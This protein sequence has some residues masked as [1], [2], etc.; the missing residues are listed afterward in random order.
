M[1][2]SRPESVSLS[3]AR[4]VPSPQGVSAGEGQA[5]MKPFGRNVN[6]GLRL[7]IGFLISNAMTVLAWAGEHSS[8]TGDTVAPPV[9]LQDFLDPNS[10]N[11]GNG[12][13]DFPGKERKFTPRPVPSGQKGVAFDFKTDYD[14]DVQKFLPREGYPLYGSDA[15]GNGQNGITQK[16]K[17]F[18]LGLSVS[19]PLD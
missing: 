6:L 19:K 8:P 16:K 2:H 18:F 17:P 7:S 4:A 3:G 13:A 1:P 14:V 12:K 15:N 5:K 9:L 10:L 11:Y